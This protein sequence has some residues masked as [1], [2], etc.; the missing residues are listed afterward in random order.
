MDV[1]RRDLFKGGAVVMAGLA[2]TGAVTALGG[3]TS[4][5]NEGKTSSV[6]WDASYDV[7][8]V[9]CGFAG[10]TAAITAAESG[11]TLGSAA[12]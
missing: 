10:M 8:V 3:C 9:G 1:S 5:P 4:E 7:V 6:A 11:A 12:R 2:A